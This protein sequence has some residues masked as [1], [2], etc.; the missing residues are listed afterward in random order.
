MS[1]FHFSNES[2]LANSLA[3]LNHPFSDC[4]SN[5]L[6]KIRKI[7]VYMSIQL[8]QAFRVEL[9]DV[10]GVERAR[11]IIGDT[12]SHSGYSRICSDHTHASVFVSSRFVGK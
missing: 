4:N 6:T 11:K 1:F 2:F 9:G 10:G 8:I 12:L 7:I 3:D 5:I